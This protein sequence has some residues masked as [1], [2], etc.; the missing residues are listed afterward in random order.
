MPSLPSFLVAML[1][2]RQRQPPKAI[3]SRPKICKANMRDAFVT[4]QRQDAEGMLSYQRLH[5]REGRRWCKSRKTL[6][7]VF[8]RRRR[9]ET[10]EYTLDLGFF[11][12][13]RLYLVFAIVFKQCSNYLVCARPNNL[14]HQAICAYAFRVTLMNLRTRMLRFVFSGVPNFSSLYSPRYAIVSKTFRNII[15]G[16]QEGYSCH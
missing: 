1:M 4:K 3:V 14:N 12:C 15:P 11:F 9:F 6:D 8:F 7:N 10:L 16:N 5:S 2:H 13:R